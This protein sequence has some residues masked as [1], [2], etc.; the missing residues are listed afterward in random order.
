MS[1]NRSNWKASQIVVSLSILCQSSWELSCDDL[2]TLRILQIPRTMD[3]FNVE[4]GRE[5]AEVAHSVADVLVVVSLE[6]SFR[7]GDSKRALCSL[8]R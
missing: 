8:R 2:D 4:G 7:L 6:I 3:F 1:K 5:L